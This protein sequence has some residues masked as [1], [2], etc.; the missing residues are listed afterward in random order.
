MKFA[1]EKSLYM[2]TKFIEIKY[3]KF[4]AETMISFRFRLI[5][6]RKSV[7]EPPFA[8]GWCF[9]RTMRGK[10]NFTLRGRKKRMDKRRL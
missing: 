10:R 3:S 4:A 1:D 2:S 9:S 5:A 8:C 7:S 6:A